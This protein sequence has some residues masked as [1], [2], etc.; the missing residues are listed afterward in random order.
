VSVSTAAITEVLRTVY[1]NPRIL[2][3]LG[4]E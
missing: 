4:V 2:A 1:P 3:E